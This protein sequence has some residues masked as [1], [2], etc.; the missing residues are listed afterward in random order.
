MAYFVFDG[1]IS[2]A[3]RLTMYVRNPRERNRGHAFPHM[4]PW[5]K[6]KREERKREKQL[7][8]LQNQLN[9][10]EQGKKTKN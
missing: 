6:L 10:T 1:R 8:K 7:R 9:V 2:S 5:K 3:T 4:R